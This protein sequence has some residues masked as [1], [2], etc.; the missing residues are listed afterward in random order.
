M[1]IISTSIGYAHMYIINIGMLDDES[2]F[3][4]TPYLEGMANGGQG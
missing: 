3:S 4:T 2:Q 1:T